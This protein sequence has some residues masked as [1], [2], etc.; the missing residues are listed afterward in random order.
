M[1]RIVDATTNEILFHAATGIFPIIKDRR[2]KDMVWSLYM[3][4][5]GYADLCAYAKSFDGDGWFYIVIPDG[6]TGSTPWGR[7]CFIYYADSYYQE[8]GVTISE[9]D[10]EPNP[11]LVFTGRVDTGVEMLTILRCVGCLREI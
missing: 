9:P 5:C 7:M 8:Q 4:S 2:D 10:L 6:N 3:P 11:E 1:S